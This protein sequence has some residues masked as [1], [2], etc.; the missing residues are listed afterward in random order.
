MIIQINIISNKNSSKNEDTNNPNYNYKEVM[1]LFEFYMNLTEETFIKK[2]LILKGLL[3]EKSKTITNSEFDEITQNFASHFLKII[4][5]EFLIELGTIINP[6]MVDQFI[7][8]IIRNRLY[9]EII[10]LN[11]NVTSSGE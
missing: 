10:K 5:K 6:E 7:I 9:T 11:L 1:D 4:N 8:T 3:I 2:E